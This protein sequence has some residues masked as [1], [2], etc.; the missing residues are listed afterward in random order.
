MSECLSG[1]SVT[2]VTTS[3]SNNSF[4]ALSH[5]ADEVLEPIVVPFAENV[6]QNIIFMD[7]NARAH[8]AR[9]VTEFLE[10]QRIE[11]MEWPASYRR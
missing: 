3:C 10:G 9:L 11:R 2:S 4:T 8:R 6:G 7:D 1:S 5:G